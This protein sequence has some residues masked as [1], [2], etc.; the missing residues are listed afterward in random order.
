VDGGYLRELSL[1][2]GITDEVYTT[3]TAMVS[4]GG[5]VGNRT[6]LRLGGTYGNWKTPV[7]SGV[8]D[9]MDVYGASLQ[10]SLKLTETVEATAAYYYYHHLYSNPGTLPE[11]FPAQYDRNAFRVGISLWVP[12]AGTPSRPPLTRR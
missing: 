10:V 11:G 2:Q 3:D 1:L 5:L 9:E 8:S 7:A 12:L 4:L 6:S